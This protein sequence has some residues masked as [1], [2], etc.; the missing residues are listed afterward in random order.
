MASQQSN[1]VLKMSKTWQIQLMLPCLIL[2]GILLTLHTA[3]K[4]SANQP[5]V[6]D[7]ARVTVVIDEIDLFECGDPA[8]S[9]DPYFHVTID[10]VKLNE[11]SN[12]INYHGGVLQP[13]NAIY[14]TRVDASKTSIPI[15]IKL[16][17]ADFWDADDHCDIDPGQDNDINLMLDLRS[18]VITGDASER[19]GSIISS[20]GTGDEA[21]RVD[22][23]ID[24]DNP[25]V[26]GVQVRCLH[27]PLRPQAGQTVTITA[28]ALDD[29]NAAM[30]VDRIDIFVDSPTPAATANFTSTVTASASTMADI[31]TY[32]CAVTLHSDVEDTGEREVYF[33]SVPTSQRAV[34]VLK[35]RPQSAAVDLVFFADRNST[36]A[37]ADDPAFLDD[38]YDVLWDGLYHERTFLNWQASINIWI[39]RD[40]ATVNP[41]DVCKFSAPGHAI[42]N[43]SFADSRIILQTHGGGCAY[44]G[45]GI[46][47]FSASNAQIMLHEMGHAPFGL[48][49]EYSNSDR[50]TYFEARY[51]PNIYET[52]AR[53]ENDAPS[54]GKTTCRQFF[55]NTLFILSNGTPYRERWY[56]SDPPT[57]DLMVDDRD[58]Q[59]LDIRRIDDIF[60]R[61]CGGSGC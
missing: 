58:P 10:D 3:A 37:S 20:T 4:S 46:A 59:D 12:E 11:G 45:W 43:F 2:F 39:A 35:T 36:Y 7:T 6:T 56:T 22:Y 47:N 51:L 32:K 26:T 16:R 60:F 18:C 55:G 14:S 34:E 53:C 5:A 52:R 50:T 1:L 42:E 41:S 17:E 33:G 25:Q 9:P 40:M 38:V 57:N 44:R 30:N 23:H 54:V 13:S 29:N 48:S 49:D 28:E 8:T 31:L 61:S 15:V 21:A 19:C 24:L 27:D